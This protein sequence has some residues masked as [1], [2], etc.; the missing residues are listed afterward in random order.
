MRKILL[1]VLLFMSSVVMGAEISGYVGKLQFKPDFANSSGLNEEAWTVD[2]R[3]DFA[4]Q[5]HFFIEFGIGALFLD[6]NNK[7]EQEVTY[8]NDY[9]RDNYYQDVY[10]AESSETG[11]L[12]SIASKINYP[13]NDVFS[14]NTLAGYEYMNFDREIADCETCYSEAVDIEAGFFLGLGAGIV[15]GQNVELK[16]QYKMYLTDGSDIEDQVLVGLSYIM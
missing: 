3:I 6:D 5:E 11:F 7:F 2:G 13:M 10:I 12:F 8:I 9:Y 16:F 14:I 1:I 4:I 15:F